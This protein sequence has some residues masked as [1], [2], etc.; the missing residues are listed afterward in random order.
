MAFTYAGTG[1]LFPF[2][3]D[4]LIG[5]LSYSYNPTIGDPF[6]YHDYGLVSADPIDSWVI[7]NHADVVIQDHANDRIVDLVY[8]GP[9]TSAYVDYGEVS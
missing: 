8:T 7:A 4:D 2:R 3:S 1:R 9:T 5:I 6:Y